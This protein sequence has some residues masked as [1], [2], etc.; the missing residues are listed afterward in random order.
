MPSTVSRVLCSKVNHLSAQLVVDFAGEVA[1]Q[2]I[3]F[4]DWKRVVARGNAEYPPGQYHPRCSH[5]T[6]G[7]ELR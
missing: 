1:P 7:A 6:C 4:V 3:V 5:R 2:G